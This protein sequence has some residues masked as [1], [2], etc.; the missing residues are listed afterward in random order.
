MPWFR[1]ERSTV[2]DEH[3]AFAFDVFVHDTDTIA[4]H[5]ER[6]DLGSDQARGRGFDCVGACPHVDLV[7]RA[8]ASPTTRPTI[9]ASVT[10][11]T[12]LSVPTPGP[13]SRLFLPTCRLERQP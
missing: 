4:I 5:A 2:S 8:P 9:P 10:P 13:E 3:G 11:T 7:L 12:D 6:A 1:I